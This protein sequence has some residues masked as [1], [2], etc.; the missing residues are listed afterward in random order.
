[1][2]LETKI[3]LKNIISVADQMVITALVA[4]L[5]IIATTRLIAQAVLAIK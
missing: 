1:M 4:I 2:Q 3:I 5:M